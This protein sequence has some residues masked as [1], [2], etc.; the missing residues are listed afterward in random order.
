MLNVELFIQ[1]VF[2]IFFGFFKRF[3]NFT[4]LTEIDIKIYS[5]QTI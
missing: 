2:S 4:F 5:N 3:I 1:Q